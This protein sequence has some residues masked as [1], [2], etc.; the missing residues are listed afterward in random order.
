MKS[1]DFSNLMKES[2]SQFYGTAG[3]FFSKKLA[4]ELQE[5]PDATIQEL[6]NIYFA[7]CK[8]LTP[9]GVTPEQARV[10]NRFAAVQLAGSLAAEFGILPFTE[11]EIT[12]SVQ[13]V[14]NLSLTKT[15]GIADNDRAVIR[16]QDFIIRNHAGV[17]SI[18]DINVSAPKCFRDPSKNIYIFSD[19]QLAVPLP[20]D[21]MTLLVLLRT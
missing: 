6:R 15:S 10:I 1:A 13:H 21:Q 18:R 9:E 20:V 5:D 8:K 12:E 11:A 14:L 16:L 3:I 7:N 4:A 2:C 17:P 19:E